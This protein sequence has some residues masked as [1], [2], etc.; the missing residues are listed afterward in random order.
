M[1]LL[2]LHIVAIAALIAVSGGIAY[3]M[4]KAEGVR[5]TTLHYEDEAERTQIERERSAEAEP[6]H[7]A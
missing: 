7:N 6:A 4:G 5:I 2:S 1:M 3:S